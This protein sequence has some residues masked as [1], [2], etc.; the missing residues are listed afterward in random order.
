MA[1]A[2]RDNSRTPFLLSISLT[3]REHQTENMS[4]SKSRLQYAACLGFLMSSILA[5]AFGCHPKMRD[6]WE[7]WIRLSLFRALVTKEAKRK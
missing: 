2:C 4:I 1:L 3:P 5:H 6:R 7:M